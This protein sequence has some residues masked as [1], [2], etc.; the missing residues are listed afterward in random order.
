METQ[1]TIDTPQTDIKLDISAAQ[2]LSTAAG[3]AKFLAILGFIASAIVIIGGM[4]AAVALADYGGGSNGV[5]LIM[6]LIYGLL[7]FLPAMWLYN[8]SNK[9]RLAIDAGDSE[10]LKIALRNL[11]N[12]FLFQGVMI[13]SL[14]SIYLIILMA[15]GI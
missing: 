12:F 11:K 7:M 2:Y 3:W 13:I 5:Y 4:V 6:F 14:L 15:V 1:D 9:S 10:E 8:F